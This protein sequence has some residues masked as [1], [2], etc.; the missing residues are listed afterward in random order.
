[1]PTIKNKVVDV[2]V[3]GDGIAG[4]LAALAARKRRAH[5]MIVEKSQANVPHGNTAF[6]GGALRRVSTKYPEE[7]YFADIMKV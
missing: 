4:C 7:K 1:M 5:V 6:C 3:I 2:L